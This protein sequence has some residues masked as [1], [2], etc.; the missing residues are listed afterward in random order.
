M[1]F[2][3]KRQNLTVKEFTLKGDNLEVG[4]NGRVHHPRRS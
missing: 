2:E 4:L 1:A 3:L